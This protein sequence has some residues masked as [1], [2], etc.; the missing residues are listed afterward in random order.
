M[1]LKNL[2]LLVL[3]PA[4]AYS[5]SATFYADTSRLWDYVGQSREYYDLAMETEWTIKGRSLRWGSPPVEVS[6][7]ESGVDTIFFRLHESAEWDTLI[8]RIK[9]GS[10]STFVYNACCTYFD[11]IDHA[12]KRTEGKVSFELMGLIPKSKKYLGT[13][14][15]NGVLLTSTAQIISPMY[16]SPMFPNSYNV[17]IRE[18]RKC[19][20]KDCEEAVIQRPD[21]SID[22]SYH[23][24][25]VDKILSFHY[26]PVSEDPIEVLYDVESGKVIVR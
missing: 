24:R 18:I 12:G 15:G 6:P 25:I 2:I 26:L 10:S 7:A 5:Q 19:A 20:G 1:P 23:Y 4:F 17:A 9:S 22:L 8:C 11:V 14:D 13:I 16:R 3:F 21:G